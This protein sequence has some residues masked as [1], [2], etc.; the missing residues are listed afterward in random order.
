MTFWVV[1]CFFLNLGEIKGSEIKGSAYTISALDSGKALGSQ[2]R[3]GSE[4]S[5]QKR[6]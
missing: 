5:S 4:E 6:T 2:W 3:P 1:L